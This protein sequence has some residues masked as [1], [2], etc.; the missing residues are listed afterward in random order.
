M[1]VFQQNLVHGKTCL[2]VLEWVS[3][4]STHQHHLAGLLKQTLLAA[5]SELLSQCVWGQV[6]PETLHFQ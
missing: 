5:T 1:T 2:P 3:D 4:M 6:G